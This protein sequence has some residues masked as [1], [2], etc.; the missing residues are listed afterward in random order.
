MVKAAAKKKN[1]P[2]AEQKQPQMKI[3]SSETCAVCKTPC[4]RGIAYLERLQTPGSVG[5]GFRV[6]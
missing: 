3:V 5:K 4:A 2:P 6:C 1:A